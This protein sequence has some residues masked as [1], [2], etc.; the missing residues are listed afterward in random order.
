V[1]ATAK[2]VTVGVILTVLPF[3]AVHVLQSSSWG[4]FVATPKARQKGEPTAPILMVE[5]SDFQCPMCARVQPALE[6]LLEK[7]K[8]KVRLAYK[9][10]PLQMHKNAFAASQAAEC[11]ADQDKFWAF[12]DRL[13]ALQPQWAPLADPTTAYLS[14]AGEL[15]LDS[16]RFESCYRGSSKDPLIEK[17]RAEGKARQVNATPTLFIGDERLV[18]GFIESEGARI[19]E[20]E[21]RKH[22]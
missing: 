17:D 4:Q 5:Y 12:K 6:E 19:I 10:Y 9:H 22:R 7:Y 11:A 15:K 3:L 16:A 14:I 13:Y 1:N 2:R 8:G 18:G 21:L 20:K